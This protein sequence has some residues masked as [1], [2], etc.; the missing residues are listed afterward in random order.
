MRK[1]GESMKKQ[2]DVKVLKYIPQ[3]IQS[4]VIAC[5]R[6]ERFPKGHTYNVIFKDDETSIFSDTVQ[7]LKWACNQYKKGRR[8]TIYG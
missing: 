1:G 3:E 5:E 6:W 4:D 2:I 7:G 8:G